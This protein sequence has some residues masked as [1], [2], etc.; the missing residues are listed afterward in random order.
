[1]KSPMSQNKKENSV[2]RFFWRLNQV[3]NRLSGLKDKVDELEYSDEDKE[4]K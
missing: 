1:M 4:K 3:K 2:E